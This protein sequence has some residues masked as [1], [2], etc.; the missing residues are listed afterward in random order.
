MFEACE[1][2]GLG[3]IVDVCCEPRAQDDVGEEEGAMSEGM[4][5]TLKHHAQQ[6]SSTAKRL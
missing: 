3:D 6:L 2:E 5:R 1:L 4:D